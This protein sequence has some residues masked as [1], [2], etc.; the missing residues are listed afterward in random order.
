MEENGKYTYNDYYNNSQDYVNYKNDNVNTTE[1][2]AAFINI[3]GFYI[4][5]LAVSIL[6]FL[7]GV[8]GNSLVIWI[9]GL[10]MKKTVNTTWY[11]S[12]AVSDLIFCVTF[13]LFHIILIVTGGSILG[14]FMFNFT[15]ALIF[16]TMFSSIFLLVI[17]SV[18][19]YVW[20]VFPVWA[21]NNRTIDMASIVVILAWVSSVALTTRYMF[22]GEK[23]MEKIILSQFIGGFAVPFLIIFFCYCV[24]ILRLRTRQMMN[25]SSKSLRVMT[26][27]ITMFFICWLPLHVFM[28]L[29][30]YHIYSSP[31]VIIPGLLVA[32]MLATVP[33]FLRPVLYVCMGNNVPPTLKRSIVG[34]IENVLGE[35]DPPTTSHETSTHL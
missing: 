30:Q 21:Q 34:R 12:L 22:V 31:E 2:D 1:E 33:S 29:D 4:F 8:P 19:R 13:S 16:I 26:V 23:D 3:H 9:T 7:I 24:T 20:V 11:L 5:Y 15:I 18:D 10:K 25:V 14:V 28:L 17:I 32:I 35:E 27:L 6:I